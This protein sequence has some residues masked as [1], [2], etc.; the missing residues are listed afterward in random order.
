VLWNGAWQPAASIA[1]VTAHRAETHSAT[2]PREALQR[3][4]PWLALAGT[5]AWLSFTP[6]TADVPPL[7]IDRA[8]AEAAATAALAERGM[9]LPPEWHRFSNTRVASAEEAQNLWHRFV[10][11][12]AGAQAYRE[13]V[14]GTL[15]PPMW[16]VRFVRFEGD[17]ADRA[18]EW[19][20]TIVGN[21]QVRQ[22]QHRLPEAA[23]AASLARDAALAIAQR[24]VRER[25]GLDPAALQLRGADE[26]R[27]DARSD[28]TFTFADPNVFV[29]KDGEARVQV[30]LAGDEVIA[31]GRAV[32][33]PEAWQRNETER[34]NRLQAVKYAGIFSIVLGALAALVFAVISWSRDQ[35]DKRAL[36]WVAALVF[37]AA[38]FDLANGWPDIA[39]QLR[40][41]EPV[42]LQVA[43]LLA[44]GLFVALLVA[45][46]MGLMSGVGAWHAR[47]QV[48]AFPAE[49][50]PAWAVGVAVALAVA[51][52]AAAS[53]TLALRE[54]PLWPELKMAA[55]A[56]PLAG[57]LVEPFG[58]VPATGTALFVLFLLD[59]G[60]RRWT[61]RLWMAALL[62]VSISFVAALVGGGEPL[63]ALARGVVKGLLTFVLLWQVLR[64]D[65]RAIPAFLATG[66][67]LEAANNAAL[68]GSYEAWL[69]FAVSALVTVAVTIGVTRYIARPLAAIPTGPS[70]RSE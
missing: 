12:E 45:G 54:A 33:V 66:M 19:R 65:L 41:A 6:F 29:G 2:A 70:P 43:T 40:T 35:C 68:E 18:E 53:E 52:L 48:R 39:M 44:S 49:R 8:G 57:A 9:T 69:R 3:A 15:A 50:L 27:R 17:V 10:W 32:F 21:G 46:L 30:V 34:N 58:L 28:W 60:T 23:P 1:Q 22:V 20:V 14:G 25:F 5:A 42:T 63:A 67:V 7:A 64:Y 31:A 56:W 13:M 62:L 47:S 4:L 61:E 26:T 16:E 59:R 55:L 51:G 36:H 37:V 11:R 24:V 38:V